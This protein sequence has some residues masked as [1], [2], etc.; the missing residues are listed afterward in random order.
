[1]FS[2]HLF[3]HLHVFPQRRRRHQTTPRPARNKM[4]DAPSPSSKRR[5][6]TR[7]CDYCKSRKRRCNGAKPCAYCT[8]HRTQC[9]YDAPY[10]RG[11]NSHFLTP[12]VS[13][14][15]VDAGPGN[16]FAPVASRWPRTSLSQVTPDISKDGE[17]SGTQS[18]A[19]SP[20]GGESA[21]PL[22]QQYLGPTSPFSVCLCRSCCVQIMSFI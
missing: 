22:G 4:T 14:D 16:S 17:V 13:V 5:R 21:A 11:K 6:V 15:D 2:S 18:R 1:M 12:S 7:A 8:A 20:V 19:R 3:R 9:T 10:T